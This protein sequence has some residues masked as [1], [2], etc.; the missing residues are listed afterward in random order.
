MNLYIT[1]SSNSHKD[2]DKK[3]ITQYKVKTGAKY[4]G[5]QLQLRK[6]EVTGLKINQRQ[7]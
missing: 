7:T 2:Q 1:K 3:K 4:L 6:L 5:N